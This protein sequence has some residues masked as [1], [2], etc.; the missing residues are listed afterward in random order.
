MR[1]SVRFLPLYCHDGYQL[2]QGSLRA[3]DDSAAQARCCHSCAAAVALTQ[4]LTVSHA[5]RYRIRHGIGMRPYP[6]C[7]GMPSTG[8]ICEIWNASKMMSPKLRHSTRRSE[9]AHERPAQ[10]G[11]ASWKVRR[12][13]VNGVRDGVWST[14]LLRPESRVGVDREMLGVAS[15][16]SWGWSAA[17]VALSFGWLR[18]G[19]HPR[20]SSAFKKLCKTGPSSNWFPLLPCVHC[21]QYYG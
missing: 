3:G 19:L 15:A 21:R 4:G 2:G 8:G 6:G 9:N 11:S 1:A 7:F 13:E 14:S 10:S 17:I 5:A 16:T 18:L 12:C 20:R